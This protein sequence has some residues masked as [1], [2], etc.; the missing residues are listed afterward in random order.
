MHFDVIDELL[1]QQRHRPLLAGQPGQLH[2][3]LPRGELRVVLHRKREKGIKA[4]LGCNAAAALEPISQSTSADPG[5][6]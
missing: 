5:D 6:V 3:K 4:L 2:A 1:H